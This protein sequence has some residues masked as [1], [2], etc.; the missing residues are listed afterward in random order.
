MSNGPLFIDHITDCDSHSHIFINLKFIIFSIS[1]LA[2]S[3]DNPL[4]HSIPID[5]LKQKKIK[6]KKKRQ[7][8][9]NKTHNRITLICH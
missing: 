8:I 1:D 7:Q 3:E 5:F 4:E 6:N 9:N 2:D